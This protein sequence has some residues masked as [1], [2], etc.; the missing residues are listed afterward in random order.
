MLRNRLIILHLLLALV[1]GFVA[2]NEALA[3][4]AARTDL[5][6]QATVLP[7]LKVNSV[8]HVKSFQVTDE[9]LRRGYADL[10]SAITVSYQTNMATTITV[11]VDSIGPEQIYV[12]QAGSPQR[13]IP[14]P[15]PATCAVPSSLS[16][17]LRVMLP[18]NTVAGIYPLN[19]AIIPTVL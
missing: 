18:L 2:S 19:L 5:S 8:Q 1:T 13:E 3:A 12:Q 17:N 16:L 10:T 4:G 11:A 7:W 9:D 6:V 15:I 14:L